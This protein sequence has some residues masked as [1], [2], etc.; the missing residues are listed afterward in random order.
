[1]NR[2]KF[3][4]NTAIAGAGL[5]VLGA[6]TNP[7]QQAQ[8]KKKAKNIIFLVS[9]GMSNG[10]LTM[11]DTLKHKKEGKGSNW[12]NL[13]RENL[14][15]RSL[16][17]MASA[18]SLVTD[19]AAASSSWGGGHRIPNGAINVGRGGEEHQPLWRKF[20][21][22]GKKTGIV[23]SVPV[24]HA[25]PAGFCTT[26]KSRNDQAGIALKYLSHGPNVILGGGQKYFDANSR[27]DRR[28]LY[29]EFQSKSYGVAKNKSQFNQINQGNLLGVFDQE[30]LPY[31]LDLMHNKDLT[32]KVPTLAEMTQKAIDLMKN[33]QEGFVL[34]V[35]GGKVDWA[36]HA[37]DAAALLYDQLAFDEAIEVAMN[38]AQSNE[39][40][41]VIVTTDHGNAN[42]G[43][44]Y[45]KNVNE[46][47]DRLQHFKATNDWVL[48]G[49]SENDSVETIRE[50]IE[51]ANGFGIQKEEA[52]DLL[53][54][55]TNLE[56]EEGLYNYRNLPFK[57]LSQIQQNYHSVGWASGNHTSDF[58]ELAAFGPGKERINA[59]IKNTDL[60]YI[61]LEAAEVENKI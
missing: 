6:C 24:T 39:D 23:T 11:A 20:K 56:K 42:P 29:S 33:H 51:F 30:G 25:T 18:S 16:M 38:F 53:S 3:F 59:F 43:M 22:A 49:I 50:R 44:L 54:Y 47:F 15:T 12:L 28:N 34:Q 21:N 19:S 5:G 52:K 36:A 14:V 4:R 48:Q 26:S 10:T 55:Y 45:G 8:E 1:M 31:S 46:N 35:E 27:E 13:Y 17:D 2:R 61:L 60:H 9:D 58:V 41:L 7:Q 37:N 32:A 57:R 40:T